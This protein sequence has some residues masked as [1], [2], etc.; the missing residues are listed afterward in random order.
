MQ[1][2]TLLDVF[3]N[4][5]ITNDS[6]PIIIK[7]LNTSLE[8]LDATF[9]SIDYA[10]LHEL[11]SMSKLETLIICDGDYLGD[12]EGFESLKQQLPN[13]SIT[14]REEIIH[15]ASPF[16]RSRMFHSYFVIVQ[17]C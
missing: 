3:V 4:E 13:I 2:N 8:K 10:A 12:S 11:K 1:Q 16:K 7:H 14:F 9:T 5:Q 6:V 17:T 15:V